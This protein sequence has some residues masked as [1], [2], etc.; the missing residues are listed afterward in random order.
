MKQE[1]DYFAGPHHF[2]THLVCGA[3]FGALL[4]AWIGW[5]CSSNEW[6]MVLTAL[7]VSASFSYSSAR[8]GDRA[9]QWLIQRLHWFT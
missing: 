4:G 9:W 5:Q 7:V 8:W 2:W 3:I 6:I 1:D